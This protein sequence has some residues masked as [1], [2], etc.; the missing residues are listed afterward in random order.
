MVGGRVR[1]GRRW[2]EAAVSGS[3]EVVVFIYEGFT[4]SGE[5]CAAIG[6]I[7]CA[8]AVYVA[9]PISGEHA[10]TIQPATFFQ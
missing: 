4:K 10:G 6:S 2:G 8:R 9:I 5:N 3:G 7:D 1:A